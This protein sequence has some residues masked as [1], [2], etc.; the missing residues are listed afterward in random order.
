MHDDCEV[1]KTEP[2]R[3]EKLKDYVQE[4][5][6]RGVLQFSGD[7]SLGEVFVIEPI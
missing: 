7:R 6:N 5:M 1:C 4:L 3:C 2:D